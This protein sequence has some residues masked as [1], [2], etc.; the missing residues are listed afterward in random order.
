MATIRKALTPSDTQEIQE[1]M[2]GGEVGNKN[3]PTLQEFIDS[4]IRQDGA[5]TGSIADPLSYNKMLRQLS[6][7][8]VGIAKYI[9]SQGRPVRDSDTSSNIAD[10]FSAAIKQNIQ[11]II[12]PSDGSGG[13]KQDVTY[14]PFKIVTA[15]T[16]PARSP[17]QIMEYDIGR[18]S[19]IAFFDGVY[20]EQG[21]AEDE[22]G[23]PSWYEVGDPTST[24]TTVKFNCELP[25]G[26]TIT[27]IRLGDLRYV[28]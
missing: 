25:A 16:T 23:T 28:L 22:L 26:V 10:S 27:F 17:L 2:P 8:V 1:W 5:L 24:S 15:Q 13:V 12:D 4:A 7:V 21:T 3:L 14:E 18:K 6:L 19:M 11:E 20:I 9:A